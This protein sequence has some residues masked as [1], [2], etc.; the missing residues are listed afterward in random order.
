MDQL[1]SAQ[2]L[3]RQVQD[4]FEGG[5]SVL[6]AAYLNRVTFGDAPLREEV[7][8]LFLAQVNGMVRTLDLPMNG[9]TWQF[10]SHT[11][12]GAAAAVGATHMSAIATN[13]EKRD[14]PKSAIEGSA[15]AAELRGAILSFERAVALLH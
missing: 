9:A 3:H 10:L 14:C 7:V 2:K 4:S 11:L 13:W 5:D 15:L 6:D 12:K 8:G 1:G